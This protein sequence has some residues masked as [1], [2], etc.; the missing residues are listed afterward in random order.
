MALVFY[1]RKE[2]TLLE[3]KTVGEKVKTSGNQNQQKKNEKRK[4]KRWTNPASQTDYLLFHQHSICIKSTFAILDTH[5]A[6]KTN[7]CAVL[8]IKRKKIPNY[9]DLAKN[10]WIKGWCKKFIF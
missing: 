3:K 9:Y 5:S 2:L 7:I 10:G 8:R 6:S 1:P 4:R